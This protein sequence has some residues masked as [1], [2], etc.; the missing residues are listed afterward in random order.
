MNRLDQSQRRPRLVAARFDDHRRFSGIAGSQS[1]SRRR[2]VGITSP[3]R[4][5][6]GIITHR[7]AK[8]LAENPGRGWTKSS[9]RVSPFKTVR[10]WTSA[11]FIFAML[12]PPITAATRFVRTNVSTYLLGRLRVALVAH[13]SAPF[14]KSSP[15]LRADFNSTGRWKIS[16]TPCATRNALKVLRT[17]PAF[18]WR[19]WPHLARAMVL[20]SIFIKAF[21]GSPRRNAGIWGR[22]DISFQSSVPRRHLNPPQMFLLH[23]GRRPHLGDADPSIRARAVRGGWPSSRSRNRGM[24]NSF[25]SVVNSTLPHS[26]LILHLFGFCR[27]AHPQHRRELRRV[28]S[29]GIIASGRSGTLA[30]RPIS[31]LRRSGKSRLRFS[32]TSSTMNRVY[33]GGHRGAAAKHPRM[34]RVPKVYFFR[35][36][37][38]AAGVVNIPLICGV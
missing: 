28:I 9:P 19:P 29:D 6:R 20:D 33:C 18:T 12:R 34:P 10:M 8:L 7:R 21:V 14:K 38:R 36:A 16:S 13:G 5:R 32:S 17:M 23:R 31:V 4:L 35:R 24:K 11:W 26:S 15:A 1:D 27:D 25:V 30:A 2:I 22:T 37:L 3:Q